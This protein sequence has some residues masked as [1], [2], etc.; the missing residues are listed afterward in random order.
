MVTRSL[1][2]LGL[3]GVL[4]TAPICV[5]EGQHRVLGTFSVARDSL[6]SFSDATTFSFAPE[7]SRSAQQTNEPRRRPSRGRYVA[8][9]V[10]VGATVGLAIGLVSKA[11]SS[12]CTDCMIP[13]SVIPVAG[14]VAGTLVGAVGGLFTWANHDDDARRARSRTA[15]LDRP[16]SR[17]ITERGS[18]P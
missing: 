3:I 1:S 14:A 6:A 16:A 13:T 9:G 7:L 17:A 4:A 18:P 10:A 5:V 11:R 8:I 12:E 15:R 2:Q